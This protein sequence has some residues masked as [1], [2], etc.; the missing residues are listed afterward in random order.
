MGLPALVQPI[1]GVIGW[2]RPVLHDFLPREDP[3]Y[4][5]AIAAARV[6]QMCTRGPIIAVVPPGKRAPHRTRANTFARLFEAVHEGVFVGTL[7]LDPL[8]DGTTEAINPFLKA[9]LGYAPGKAEE[10]VTTFAP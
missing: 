5:H 1:V 6:A 10:R 3:G 7:P 9:M 2:N 4:A 8:S